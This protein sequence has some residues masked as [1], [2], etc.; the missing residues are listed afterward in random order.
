M[1]SSPD[2]PTTS[3]R[4]LPYPD[5]ASFRP[6][7]SLFGYKRKPTNEFLA[8][9]AELLRY[10]EEQLGKAQAELAEHRDREFA[11]NEALLSIARVAEAI[12]RD[13]RLEAETIRAQAHEVEEFVAGT[14]SQ[15]KAFLQET[16]ARLGQLPGGREARSRLQSVGVREASPAQPDLAR[17][18]MPSEAHEDDPSAMDALARIDQE[19]TPELEKHPAGARSD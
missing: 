3:S 9:V 2:L 18:L 4:L 14:R 15:L 5:I 17:E 7:R 8:H 16:L 6:G 1:D 12:K 11:L 10:A 19:L 13:A